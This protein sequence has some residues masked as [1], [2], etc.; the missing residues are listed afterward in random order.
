[1]ANTVLDVQGLTKTIGNLILFKDISFSIEEG[2]SVGLIARNGAGKSSLLNIICGDEDYD[3]GKIVFRKDLCIGY[4]SQHPEFPEDM[5]VMEACFSHGSDTTELIKEYTLSLMGNHKDLSKWMERMEAAN[6]WDYETRVKQVLTQLNI[7]DYEQ[8]ISELSGGQKKRIAIANAL[9]TEPDLLVL[10]E[11]TNHLD[12][13]MIEWL[14]HYLQG[15][16][17]SM[18]MVT[19]DRY[20]LDRVCSDILELDDETIYS[21]KGNYSYYLKRRQERIDVRNSVI[22]RANNLYRKELEWMRRMPSARGHKAKY[23]EENFYEIEKKAKQQI[24]EKRAVLEVR[25]TYIGNKIFEARYISKSFGDKVILKEF[26]Y[27]FSRYEKMGIVGRNGTGKTTFIKL[28]LGLQKP[29]SGNISV[30]ETVRFG[31]YSQEGMKFD[32]SMRVI[33]AVRDIAEYIDMDGGRKLTASQFLQHFLFTPEQQH[34]YIYKLSGGERRRLYLCTVLMTNPNFLVLDEPT[35]DLDII[36][37]QILEEYLQSFKGCV[38]IVSHDRY[39]MDKVV[40]HLLV[41]YGDGR[42]KDF[43]GNYTQYREWE[44]YRKELER[45]NEGKKVVPDDNGCAK[46]VRLTSKRKLTFKEQKEFES[47]TSEID[48]MESEKR[49][50]EDALCSGT[51]SVSEITEMS[52]RLPILSQEIDDKT[53][54]WMELAEI[55]DQ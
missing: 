52:K 51:L 48:Q 21:Y 35:N 33:D 25:N 1:M 47:L 24:L 53:M 32:S 2:R 15:R 23:R 39:F 6:A 20:F 7:T 42:I 18:L 26:Y 40:D 17:M 50:I 14:E 44:D 41:F 34:N 54:R 45:A 38:I 22:A 9:M 43:P 5:T 31:Y 29:D 49:N 28:L 16:N 4:L 36:T 30:G 55:A 10:D 13:E 19:H 3:A 11:P 27:N 8:R 37:L 46:K 12:I